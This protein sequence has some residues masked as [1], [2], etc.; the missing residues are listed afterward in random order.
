MRIAIT[1]GTGFVGRHLAESLV[2]DGHEV[3]SIARRGAVPCSV[4]DE[5]ALR[6][7]FEGCDAVAHCAG[8]N[9]ELGRQT[10]RNVHVRG[11]RAV[12]RA[13]EAAGARRIVLLSFLRARPACGSP[14]HESKYAAEEIVRASGLDWTVV[15]SG[16]IYGRGDHM[17]DHLSHALHTF[18][19]F[20][21]VGFR[22]RSIAPVAVADVVRIL[23]A[24]LV[25]G[26]LSQKRVAVVGPEVIPLGDA[27]RRVAEVV[28]RN[29]FFV[30]LPV[31]SHYLLARLF[32]LAMKVP[33]VS[34]AQ[35]RILS[36]GIVEP[37]PGCDPLPTSLRP[38]TRFAPDQIRRGLP[39]PGPFGLTDLR[40]C[41]LAHW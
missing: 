16:V 28:G 15:R 6:R 37:S 2:R 17:L 41:L 11:T 18:P 40:C 24:A 35:V 21:L 29:P 30:R 33:L 19:V 36:E 31:W 22:D 1:G 32:E 4:D 26:A 25:E 27:V 5:P 7:A 39:T 13:A 10:Y 20:G 23:K 12:V 9:R 14:Y 8:I 38:S 34:A 3:V